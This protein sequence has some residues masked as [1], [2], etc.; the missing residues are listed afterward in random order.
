MILFRKEAEKIL[1]DHK[2]NKDFT[3]SKIDRHIWLV[4]KCGKQ[5]VRISDLEV[6]NKLTKTERELLIEDY[7]YPNIITKKAKINKLLSMEQSIENINK[8]L[9]IIEKNDQVYIDID[10]SYA[11]AQNIV[12]IVIQVSVNNEYKAKLKD[13]LDTSK[14]YINMND[15]PQEKTCD[16]Y[17]KLISKLPIRDRV[18]SLYNERLKLYDDV[19]ELKKDLKIVC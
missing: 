11:K 8:E 6:G 4:G 13:N 2:F 16:V 19:L 1:Q 9:S 12:Y 17:N 10:Y 18:F 7:L 15:V 5:I 3:V 14:K